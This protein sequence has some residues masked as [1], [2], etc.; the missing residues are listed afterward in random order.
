MLSELPINEVLKLHHF[1]H[2]FTDDD[3]L[4]LEPV[5]ENQIRITPLPSLAEIDQVERAR[6]TDDG[7]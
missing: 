6:T 7:P 3:N 4:V 2:V 5:G 1:L